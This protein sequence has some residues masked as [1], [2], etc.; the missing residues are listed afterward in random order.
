MTYLCTKTENERLLTS[1]LKCLSVEFGILDL[2]AKLL[3]MLVLAY[4]LKEDILGD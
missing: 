4:V 1:W 3:K 2:H